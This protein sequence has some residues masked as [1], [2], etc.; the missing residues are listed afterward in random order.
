MNDEERKEEL[1]RLLHEALTN[2]KY[3]TMV[4]RPTGHAYILVDLDDFN[5][6]EEA[7]DV[8]ER[9]LALVEK[10]DVEACHE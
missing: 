6:V 1:R 8:V 5:M 3:A 10:E 9:A 4:H 2:L 7:K